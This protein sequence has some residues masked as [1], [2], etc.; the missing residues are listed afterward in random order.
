MLSLA[1]FSGCAS[2]EVVCNPPYIHVGSDCCLDLNNNSVCDSQ[3]PTT[4]TST[5]STSS[6][7][8]STSTSSS[9]T[10]RTT[11]TS[12]TSTTSTTEPLCGKTC[13]VILY[14]SGECAQYGTI[15][16]YCV[17]ETAQ[18]DCNDG[19]IHPCTKDSVCQMTETGGHC[20][21]KSKKTAAN[22]NNSG[23]R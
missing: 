14:N 20:T 23:L 17:N 3:D 21:P 12:T 9:T 10:E 19:K 8:T 6:S 2:K 11:T 22:N 15:S 5:S 1:I 13:C 4:T 16:T 18:Y 7:S